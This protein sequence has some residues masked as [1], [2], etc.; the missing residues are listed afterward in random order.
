M[1][2]R[3]APSTFSREQDAD[4]SSVK[5]ESEASEMFAREHEV[6]DTELIFGLV[7]ALGTN[8]D[9]ISNL[10]H[11]RLEKMAYVGTE[12][13]LSALL[14]EVAW[15]EELVKSPELDTYI[16][17]HMDAGNL[18]RESWERPDALALLGVAKISTEREDP[19]KSNALGKRRAWIIRQLKT[20]EEVET[21]RNVY[22]SRFFLI[23]AYSPSDERSAWLDE[24][25]T[26]TRHSSVQ[27]KW[28]ATT[29][30][31]LQ[32]DQ[33]EGGEYGQNVRDTFHRA[34]LFVDASKEADT[35]AQL[36]RLLEVVL[37]NPFRTPTKDEFALFEATGAARLSAEPG[38]QVGAALANGQGEIIALG[39]NEVPRPGGGIYREG[40]DDPDVP[41]QREFRFGAD[42]EERR[43]DTNDRMQREIAREI[44]EALSAP[45]R[46]W[47]AE[48]VAADDLLAVIL[49]TRLGDLTEFGRAIHAEMSAILDAARNGHTVAGSTLYVTTFPCHNC[50]RHIVCAGITSCVFLA[51]YAKSQAETLHGDALVVAKGGPV[52]KKIPFNPFVGVAP[53]RYTEFFSWTRRKDEDGQLLEWVGTKAVPRLGDAEPPEL[54]QNR[55]AYRVRE[56]LI[57]G[58]LDRIQDQH[59]V[60]LKNAPPTMTQPASEKA[61]PPDKKERPRRTSSRRQQR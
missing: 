34:D 41:D 4:A 17:S 14:R 29:E 31:L 48:G 43:V 58:L 16:L 7:G 1:T 10:L 51:P 24:E 50:A 22:G 11:L 35:Q 52:G 55:P 37:A 38:R 49:S 54:R 2:S 20:P 23:A 59:G 61:I 47:L 8:M 57:S 3:K 40:G 27:S 53:R 18:L 56:D 25:I 12:I 6:A 46:S 13:H 60:R 21:L 44:A 33:S 30:Q 19:L 26:K 5:I 32:R 28:D 36:E 39:T 45:S 42:E 9:R 15:E